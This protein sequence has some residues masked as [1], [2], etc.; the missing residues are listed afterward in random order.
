MAGLVIVTVFTM[1]ACNNA[2]DS[3]N[4]ADTV[5]KRG[6]SVALPGVTHD[7]LTDTTMNGLDKTMSKDSNNQ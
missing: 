7:G 4:T 1:A 5:S 3:S 6:D 2:A